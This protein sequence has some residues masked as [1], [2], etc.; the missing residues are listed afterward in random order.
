MF[1][2]DSREGEPELENMLWEENWRDYVDDF[3]TAVME[4]SA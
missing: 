2:S 4:M 1:E 3:R